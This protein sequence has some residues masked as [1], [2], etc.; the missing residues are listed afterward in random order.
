VDERRHGDRADGQ[1]KHAE[2]LLEPEHVPPERIGHDA[3]KHR[4]GGDVKRCVRGSDTAQQRECACDRWPDSECHEGDA[5]RS[6]PAENRAREVVA[7]DESD[8]SGRADHAAGPECRTEI[9]GARRPDGQHVHREHDLEH[10]EGS[11]RDELHAHERE[12]EGDGA[13]AAQLR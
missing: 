5:D 1:P 7:A 10:V 2:P 13:V 6:R 3:V 8:R 9:S 11:Q 12:Q 4:S